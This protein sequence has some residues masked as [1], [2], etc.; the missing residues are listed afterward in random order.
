MSSI[1][2]SVFGGSGNSAMGP[3]APL[4]TAVTKEQADAARAQQNQAL[5][6]QQ[7]FAQAV[8]A[9][10][11][12]GNQSSV[13]NQLQ[14]V[15]QGT[16]P[17]PAQAQL[18]NATG[19][20]VANQAAL[21]A[22]QRGSSANAGLM[23]RQAANQGAGIQQNAAGQAA[24]LQA[25]QSL[26]AMGQMG[27]IAN[28]QA[29]QQAQATGAYTQA[30]GN[31]QGQLLNSIGNQNQNQLQQQQIQ[32]GY[33]QQKN[34]ASGK[35]FG[36]LMGAAGTALGTMY[37][38]P[39]GGAAG[40][41]LGS[42]I[43]GKVGASKGGQSMQ[44]GFAEG[45][46]VQSGPKSRIGKHFHGYKMA[47]GGAVPALVSPGEQYIPP[48]EVKKVAQGANPLS[49]GERI[50]GTPKVKG[51]SYANDTVPKTLESGGVVIPNSI[52][53]SKDADKKAAAFVQAILA[54]KG[55][56]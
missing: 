14:G 31:N 53:Q 52:M 44:N 27:N 33:D 3:G 34:D 7:A 9:Q 8:A 6:Q 56:K 47:E 51:N 12:L 43:G 22:G 23:A 11:G 16:G 54:K 49:L 48:Q 28:Q 20:N 42:S 50:P 5:A 15:A 17:N 41:A 38:G 30:T 45:G 37:G 36:N 39:V 26:N 55:K 18:A 21:M 13:F 4:T 24:A 1:V 10:N 46:A 29:A 25:Q 2:S 35:L 19:A 32:A 40:G